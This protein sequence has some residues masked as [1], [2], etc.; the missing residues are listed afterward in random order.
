MSLP[1][2]GLPLET[3]SRIA[4]GTLDTAGL[5]H[6]TSRYVMRHGLTGPVMQLI[7]RDR[8]PTEAEKALLDSRL[9]QACQAIKVASAARR[10]SGILSE[11]GLPHLFVKG[12]AL[13]A[14]IYGDWSI[15]WS[16]DLDLLIDPS[17]I[18][19]LHEVL[20]AAGLERWDGKTRSPSRFLRWCKCAVTY[21]GLEVTLDAHWRFDANPGL[22][23]FSFHD[24]YERSEEVIVAD[25]RIRTLGR[26]DSWIF[27][28]FHGFRSGWFSWK[29]LLDAAKQYA[30]LDE[31]MRSSARTRARANNAERAVAL[32]E[33]LARE[34][35]F[36]QP[37]SVIG[38]GRHHAM[39]IISETSSA[40]GLELSL[41]GV[42]SRQA[43]YMSSAPN[44]MIAIGSITR[45]IGRLVYKPSDYVDHVI[46]TLR[47]RSE[48]G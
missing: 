14:Q 10:L 30:S 28:A 7:P 2:T 3:F 47:L 23:S 21:K 22:C 15:R 13:S 25:H 38:D 9:G 6:Q 29:W 4:L 34:V 32:A 16:S 43:D 40:T 45:A 11:A 20:V 27:T 31:E 18:D 36:F 17:D 46:N 1:A 39:K 8:R 42:I 41:R 44:A 33:E 37:D 19:R 24:L 35:L 12:P 26:L 48:K 5:D